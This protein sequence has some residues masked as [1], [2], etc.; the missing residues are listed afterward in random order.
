[1]RIEIESRENIEHG[2]KSLLRD[3]GDLPYANF[4]PMRQRRGELVRMHHRRWIDDADSPEFVAARDTS[5][6]LIGALRLSHRRFESEHFGMPMA[7]LALPLAPRDRQA[8]IGVL[9]E[10]YDAAHGHLVD[11][12]YAHVA[13]RASTRDAEAS[14]VLQEQRATHVNTQVSWMCETGKATAR[15]ELPRGLYYEVHDAESIRRVEPVAW[16][17]LDEWS[18]QAFDQGPFSRDMAMPRDRS[19]AV[20]QE[21][22]RRVMS[23]DWAD[24]IFVVRNRDE[25][26]AFIALLK[27]PDISEACGA[28]VLGRGFGATLPEHQGLFTAIQREMI[29]LKPAGAAFVE[30]E[31][32]AS[33]VGSVNVYAKLGFRFLRS[34]ETFHR[35]IQ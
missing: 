20:Y 17:R 27:L 28:L 19:L 31:T 24:T 3:D 1:M 35:T 7:C 9:R 29:A 14:W 11:R 6:R 10:M 21:W 16:R 22:T 32:Q 23:G 25:I 8:R 18:A 26:V 34:I 5:G 13:A 4:R 2:L 30:N 15:D 12:G 33:T